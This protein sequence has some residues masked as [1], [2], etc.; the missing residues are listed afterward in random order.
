MYGGKWNQLFQDVEWSDFSLKTSLVYEV[1]FSRL[2]VLGVVLHSVDTEINRKCSH[3]S[4]SH[5]SLWY[6]LC[7]S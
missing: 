7:Q 2:T 6:S 1:Q 4:G 3:D 5:G